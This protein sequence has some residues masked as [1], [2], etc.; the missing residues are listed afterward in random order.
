MVIAGIWVR[1]NEAISRRRWDPGHGSDQ[2]F[3][4]TVR[5]RISACLSR[6]LASLTA[7]NSKV[8]GY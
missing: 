5:A 7:V 1:T 6:P 4:L 3:E 2:E 8:E